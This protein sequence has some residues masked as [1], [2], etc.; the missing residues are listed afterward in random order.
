[1]ET[2][3]SIL[4]K[5][6]SFLEKDDP[7]GAG[8]FIGVVETKEIVD[9]SF[10]KDLAKVCE[11]LGLIPRAI[12]EY[13]LSLRG[14]PG[15]GPVLKRLAVIYQNQ[16]QVEKAMRAWQ[17]V[18]PLAPEDEEPIYELGLLFEQNREWEAARGRPL[19]PNESMSAGSA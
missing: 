3:E 6:K 17:Q 2:P 15:Q 8:T 12:L 11:D 13:N 18:I 14:E 19:R 7:E 5:M 10:H 9:P 4:Q 16:G 1:M